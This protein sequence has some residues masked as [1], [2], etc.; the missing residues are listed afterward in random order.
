MLGLYALYVAAFRAKSNVTD[1]KTVTVRQWV[2][3]NVP[4]R[5]GT[6]RGFISQ[7][8]AGNQA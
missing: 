8:A 5:E 3:S 7:T 6:F 2:Y 4:P 1:S